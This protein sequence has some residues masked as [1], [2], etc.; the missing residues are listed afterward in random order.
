MDEKTE[1]LRDIF[2]DVSDEEAVTESQEASRGPWPIL[3]RPVSRTDS[4]MSSR[5]CASG[6]SSEPTSPTNP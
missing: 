3:T 1:E 6:T 5:G 4:V 2:M